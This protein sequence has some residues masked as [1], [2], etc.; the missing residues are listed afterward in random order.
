METKK[1]HCMAVFKSDHLSS[2]DLEEFLEDGKKLIFTIKQVKQE[3]NIMVAGKKGNHNIAYFKEDIKPMV[4]NSGNT[5]ILRKFAG[6]L[7]L[8]EDWEPMIVELYIQTGVKFGAEIKQGIRIR[9][10]QPIKI[11][12][13]LTPEHPRWQEA[14][15]AIKDGKKDGVLKIYD[16]SKE[17]LILIEK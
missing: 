14:K 2:F 12:P 13:I 11:K 17:N 6:G 9:Q 4:V 1:H 15:D 16:I 7:P 5:K 10:V 8:V 3:Y